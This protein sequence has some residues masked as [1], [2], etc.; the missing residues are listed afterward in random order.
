VI[1]LL[2]DD[3]VAELNALVADVDPGAGD[4]L[5]DLLLGLAAEGALEL[6][7][8]V[9]ELE[10]G[11]TTPLPL[12]R[13]IPDEDGVDQTILLRFLRG[14][15]VVPIGI[16]FHF[17]ER[18]PGVPG[19]DL[20]QVLLGPQNLPGLDLNIGRLPLHAAPRLVDHDPGVRQGVPLARRPGR[21]QHG[22]HA[23]RQPEADGGDGGPDMLHGVVDG[24]AGVDVP[25]WA[26]DVN[27]DVLLR[28]LRLQEEQLGDDQVGQLVVD[29][30]PD[31]DD[32]LLQEAG[33]DIVCPLATIG[34]LDHHRHQVPHPAVSPPFTLCSAS[35]R[36][37]MHPAPRR[38]L[39]ASPQPCAASSPEA[40]SVVEA[41]SSLLAAAT[42]EASS[43]AGASSGTSTVSTSD[44]ETRWSRVFRT[45]REALK[46]S[47]CSGSSR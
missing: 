40:F 38:S 25:A 32:A 11:S 12:P 42:S 6:A 5:L 43:S 34:L 14:H 10:H 26:I 3:L 16:P 20:V 47:F 46:L 18:L 4:Q 7:L 37:W 15:I 27:R 41:S 31:E 29:G 19:E 30:P 8:L 35:L 45:R 21:Q 33:V 23:G 39:E 17:L 24:Q 2:L 22:R 36:G 9:P 44:R 28:V 13:V 1:E